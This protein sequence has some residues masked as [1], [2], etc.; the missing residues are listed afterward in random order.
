MLEWWHMGNTPLYRPYNESKI[1]LLLRSLIQIYQNHTKHKRRKWYILRVNREQQVEFKSE[2]MK[3]TFEPF[4]FIQTIL[5]HWPNME[6]NQ[7]IE[8]STP[9]AEN[10]PKL[11]GICAQNCY[12]IHSCHQTE[13]I[14]TT[15]GQYRAQYT[16]NILTENQTWL[17][18]LLMA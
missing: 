8:V 1:Q 5:G 4:L 11:K 17:E 6:S 16:L 18:S 3:C 14:S 2:F 12:K 10:S 13:V 9:E 7:I 15:H